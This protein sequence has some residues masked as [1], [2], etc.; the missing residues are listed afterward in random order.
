MHRVS[1]DQ[2]RDTNIEK[3]Q[4][5]GKKRMEIEV[6]IGTKSH[7]KKVC[8]RDPEDFYLCSSITIGIIGIIA[9]Q[10]GLG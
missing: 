10:L 1:S 3:M 7:Q 8:K 5:A 6:G 9:T 4:S 2:E